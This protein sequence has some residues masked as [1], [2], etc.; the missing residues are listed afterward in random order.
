MKDI[1]KQLNLRKKLK[2]EGYKITPWWVIA[3]KL[4]WWPVVKVCLAV[5]TI[6]IAIG[7]GM[8]SAETFWEETK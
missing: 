5:T 7:F 2:K 8:G 3:W 4:L 1:I 6:A